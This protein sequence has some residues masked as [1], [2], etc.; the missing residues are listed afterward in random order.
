[1]RL[2]I[3]WLPLRPELTR[4]V[5]RRAEDMGLWGIGI[6]DSPN[7]GE[8]YSA[9]ADALAVTSSLV[10]GTSV[11]NP[12]TRHWSVAA[13]AGR[14]FED[15][16]PGRFRLGI[17]RGDSAV[18]TFGLAP[19][20]LSAMERFLATFTENVPTVRTLV[21]ASG[22]RTAR[23]AGRA[24]DGVIAG[25]GAD[26]VA[27]RT[28][29]AA[30]DVARA[31]GR[32]RT[33]IWASVRLAVGRDDTEIARLRRA[34][35]PRAVSASHFAFAATFAG[36]N[37]PE[38]FQSVLTERYA[39]YDY[40]AHGVAGKT[41]NA[42]MFADRPDIEDYLLNRFAVVGS[43]GDCAQR[44]SQ[45]SAHVDGIYLSV[46]FE[47]ALAQLDAIAEMLSAS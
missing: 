14:T 17:G 13:A 28:I 22:A 33:E 38:H 12:I 27:I 10:V 36:K 37:V 23:I 47:D 4:S 15:A 18:R 35:V 9:C 42:T 31:P 8:L 1:M 44:L 45:L 7:Y 5:A 6:G 3:N 16:Y 2:C 26:T 20:G 30:A 21:A 34:L 11:T 40:T 43:P 46:I 19:A 39:H 25:V 24:A 41:S 32:E 29:G